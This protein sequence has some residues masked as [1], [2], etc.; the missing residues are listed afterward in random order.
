MEASK[1]H[2]KKR[3]QSYP[4]YEFLQLSYRDPCEAMVVEN[5]KIVYIGS[6]AG[7]VALSQPGV[8]RTVDLNGH[9]VLPGIHDIHMHP[10]EGNHPATASCVLSPDLAPNDP[11][12][13]A[14]FTLDKCHLVQKGTKWVLG[15][16][17]YIP[18]VLDYIFE[19][20][21]DP[22]DIL[23]ELIVDEEGNRV[24][25]L[26]MEVTSHS[27]WLNS[28]GLKEAGLTRDVKNGN[29]SLYMRNE[30]GELNGMVFENAVIE[31]RSKAL[32]PELYP[33]LPDLAYEAVTA[34][35]EEL[36][37]NGITSLTD[38]RVFLARGYD[39]A[40]KRAEDEDKLTARVVMS[41]WAAP[42]KD[43][44]EQIPALR[45][46]FT[47]DPDRRLRASQVK[48]YMDGIMEARTADVL[49]DYLET[50]PDLGVGDRGVNY[51]TQEQL[52]KYL[53]ELQSIDGGQGF[54]FLVHSIGDGAARK[55]LN[56]VEA[57]AEF[58]AA[59]TRHK[60]THCELVSPEDWPRFKE[61]GVIADAQVML[62]FNLLQKG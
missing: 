34:A 35:L 40:W 54:D 58:A 17:Y 61:L 9:S 48:V 55:M 21:L 25:A 11:D 49:E 37:M 3:S 22:K 43:D 56:A 27:A 16:G 19:T 14:A 39:K 15:W 28:E 41:L 53:T 62:D 38:A 31:T 6:D 2:Y 47:N 13:L 60:L 32:N 20:G 52:Q 4:S 59:E 33:E 12:Q 8:T 26:I 10:L 23:D 30:L 36:A 57:S 44:A 18:L 51:F 24:P 45:K 50:F 7:A 29:G 1:R 46:L 5:G 42:E